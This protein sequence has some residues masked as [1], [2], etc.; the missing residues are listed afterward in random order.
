[1]LDLNLKAPSYAESKLYCFDCYSAPACL[2][3]LRSTAFRCIVTTLWRC[4]FGN[5]KVLWRQVLCQHRAVTWWQSHFFIIWYKL[6]LSHHCPEQSNSNQT[7]IK[8][9]NWIWCRHG[10]SIIIYLFLQI[11]VLICRQ[12]IHKHSLI[13]LKLWLEMV[14][15]AHKIL[16]C[17]FAYELFISRHVIGSLVP[18]LLFYFINISYI[19]L[20]H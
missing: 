3:D 7:K 4:I 16:W 17:I 11:H 18:G 2:C 5:T 19:P 15:K 10:I 13:K 20:A 8:L 14:Y 6:A 1:M 12:N 9:M